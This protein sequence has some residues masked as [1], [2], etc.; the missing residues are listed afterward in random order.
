MYVPG[1]A[2]SS[3]DQLPPVQIRAQPATFAPPPRMYAPGLEAPGLDEPTPAPEPAEARMPTE[4]GDLLSILRPRA[5]AL[6]H[7]FYQETEEVWRATG[8][9]LLGGLVGGGLWLVVA[10]AFHYESGF[11]ALAL[12]VLVGE[13]V[14][15]GVT[16]QRHRYTFYA[17]SLVF[18]CW[19]I[20]I[21]VLAAH[22]LSWSPLDGAY[23]FFA[24]MVCTSPVA[25][26]PM[27][28]FQRREKP[29]EPDM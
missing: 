9:A 23:L 5:R 25:R 7:A 28:S 6:A 18:F 29:R 17:L 20:C 2:P 4:P 27:R 12:G 19:A 14:T 8:F 10:F 11:L 24:L 16:V 15:I 21:R 3:E 26:L 13:G 22:H 1:R